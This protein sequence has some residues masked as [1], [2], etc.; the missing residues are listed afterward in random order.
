MRAHASK[1]SRLDVVVGKTNWTR[2][3]FRTH[4]DKHRSFNKIVY[5][6]GFGLP[7]ARWHPLRQH[8]TSSAPSG[9]AGRD[10]TLAVCIAS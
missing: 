10:G 1:T 6:M 7:L 8:R 4:T 5:F 3:Q 2:Y 9:L